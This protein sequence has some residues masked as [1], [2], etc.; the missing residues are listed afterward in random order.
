MEQIQHEMDETIADM[1]T[2]YQSETLREPRVLIV[3]DAPESTRLLQL[4]LEKNGC[5][6]TVVTTG[7][8]AIDE[9]TAHQYDLVFLDW[10]LPDGTGGQT[11]R[12]L[13]R[14]LNGLDP[15]ADFPLSA[16]RVPVVVYS[17]S[18]ERDLNFPSGSHFNIIAYWSKAI[19]YKDLFGHASQIV[20]QLKSSFNGEKH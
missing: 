9:L 7:S 16:L 3:D 18:A 15:I 6:P 5:A 13:D 2:S 20:L 10:T 8:D 14:L 12:R 11:L 1:M 17:S 19:P 4:S